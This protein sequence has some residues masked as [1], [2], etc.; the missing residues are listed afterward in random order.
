MQLPNMQLFF[1]L[2]TLSGLFFKCPLAYP[3]S[4][5]TFTRRGYANG[6]DELDTGGHAGFPSSPEKRW[7]RLPTYQVLIPWCF[8]DAASEQAIGAHVID[9]AWET[10]SRVLGPASVQ[11]GHNLLFYHWKAVDGN[12]YPY[13]YEANGQWNPRVP[14]ETVVV[15]YNHVYQPGV[16]AQA[17]I[18]YK[19]TENTPGRHWLVMTYDAMTRNP[20]FAVAHELGHVFGLLHEHQRP[21]RDYYVGYNCRNVFG[22]KETLARARADGFTEDQLC[23]QPGV[24]RRYG[25]AG[26]EFVKIPPI[27]TDVLTP[28]DYQSIMHYDCRNGADP[29]VYGPDP[30]N[31]LLY[32][33]YGFSTAGDQAGILPLKGDKPYPHFTISLG[34]AAAI[35]LMYP[36]YPPA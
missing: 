8:R 18:G 7:P 27:P 9:R 36:F 16:Q 11:N 29:A 35:R 33:I 15:S 34:D 22:F 26:A 3:L 6:T 23:N 17:S 2:V 25:W 12:Y 21:D 30:T 31:A 4:N 5:D 20:E 13:C 32:P 28:Y 14:P 19:A 24:A 1:I 10:W